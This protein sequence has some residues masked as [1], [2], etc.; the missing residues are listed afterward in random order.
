MNAPLS[1]IAQIRARHGDRCWLCDGLLDFAAIPNSKK[2]PTKE[3]LQ[4][5]ALGGTNDLSNLAL[6]HPGCNRHLG[7]RPRQEKERMR[8]KRLANRAKQIASHAGPAKL[9]PP[10]HH[11]SAAPFDAVQHWQKIAGAASLGAAFA[12]GLAAGILL[13]T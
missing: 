7:S 13:A 12:I 9:P 3:H 10:A 11:S 4:P 6:C 1:K 2:A 8:A 5:L